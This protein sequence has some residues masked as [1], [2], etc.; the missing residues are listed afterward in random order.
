[1][2]TGIVNSRSFLEG[3]HRIDPD[4]YLSNGAKIR[5]EIHNL[6]YELSTV[7]ENAE[8]V[9]YGNIFSRMFVSK[10]SHGVEYLAAS[11][12]VLSDLHTGRY[13]SKIQAKALKYLILE[14]GWILVTCSGTLGNVTYTTKE[15]AGK[16]A[17]HDLIRIIPNSKKVNAGTLYAFLSSKYGYFQITQ[18][19]FGGVVKHINESQMSSV[20]VPVFPESFQTEVDNLIQESARLREEANDK[21]EE[22]KSKLIE[23]CNLPFSKNYGIK[24]NSIKISNIRKTLN[25]RFDPPIYI[26][27]G[28][29]WMNSLKKETILLGD[30][31]VKTWYPGIFKRIYVKKGLPYIKGSSVFNINPFKSCDHLSST[32]TPMLDELWLK[33]GLLLIT[34]A[35]AVGLVK[36]IT[37]EYEDKGAIGSPDI[38]RLTSNDKLFTTEYL[39]TYLQLPAVYDYMQ[40][41]KYGSV[42]ERFDIANVDT[43]PIVKPTISLS[44]EI[45][46]LINTYKNCIYH[47]FNAEEKAIKMVEDE[48]E[49]WN[50][51]K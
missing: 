22:A 30:I 41:L 40:S 37:K 17:T 29:D 46:E 25:T 51:A 47:A 45:T 23:F 42:I 11:D 8:N 1:M 44:G 26:N 13:I 7:G 18:S 12:T 49:K 43:I 9:F 21:L 35:G 33:D 38:I 5:R 28:V 27:D 4:L 48:I 31:D 32:R 24:N 39:F 34:C 2:K 10:P 15:F 16:L 14:K 36:I 50:N 19:Q 20:L 3:D 6:P